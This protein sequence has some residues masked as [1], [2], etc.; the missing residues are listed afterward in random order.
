M[1]FKSEIILNSIADGVFTV[2]LDWRITYF[3][4][5]AERIIGVLKEEAV[6]KF[7]AEIFKANICERSCVM[8]RTIKTGESIVNEVVTIVR[9]DGKPLKLTVSTALLKDEKGK[10]IGGVE[11]FRDIST[12]I[13][14]RK[15]LEKSYSFED[16]IS[17]NHKMW[18]LF[19]ILP[20]IAESDSTAL[21]EGESGTGKELFARA[22]HNLSYRHDKP[23]VTVNCGALPDS[24]LEAE[25]FGVKAGAFTDAKRD[26]P[27]RFAR[28]RGGTIFLDEIGDVSPAMQARLLRV[29]QEGI[30]EP[31]GSTETEKADVRVIT[32]T[33]KSLKGLVDAGEFR[34]DLY[35]R[36]DVVR[37]EIP[38]LARRMEDIPIL[39]RHFVNMFNT[40]KNKDIQGVSE[41]VM[42]TLMRYN[43]PGNVRELENII[44][45]AF[46]LCRVGVIGIEHLPR[47]FREDREEDKVLKVNSLDELLST[48]I[49]DAL[50][51]NNWNRKKTAEQLGM[52]ETTLWRKIKRLNIE[53]PS[54]DGRNSKRKR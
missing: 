48:F 44:E 11:T 22:L 8:K 51:K 28:A 2:D 5:A 35:Y 32:A 37:L 36:I 31:L 15:R 3:N 10:V 24:L 54:V 26:K 17:K 9:A 30:Y 46:V 53:L 43:F 45:H 33:N 38:P 20:D 16:I 13:E 21:I 1:D 6:G 23:L 18:E 19:D 27:G 4:S 47:F 25:L 50:R 12:E 49:R 7:C 52:H 42:G 14:L 34:Q 41:E 29:L 40:L 39:V